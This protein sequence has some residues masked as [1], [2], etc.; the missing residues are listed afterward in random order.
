M[1]LFTKDCDQSVMRCSLFRV[2]RRRQA[3]APRRVAAAA[4][5]L[6]YLCAMRGLFAKFAMATRAVLKATVQVVAVQLQAPDQPVN[7][8]FASGWAASVTSVPAGRVMVQAVPVHV[9]ASPLTVARTV[10]GPD[11]K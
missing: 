1:I 7:T 5:V 10:P 6:R 3:N 9:V 8:P 2:L 4:S 11:R